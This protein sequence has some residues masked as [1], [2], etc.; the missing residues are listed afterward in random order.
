MA[1]FLG[2]GLAAAFFLATFLPAGRGAVLVFIVGAVRL[3][4]GLTFAGWLARLR[5][6][7]GAPSAS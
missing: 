4:R 5:V 3:T 2:S 1:P 7:V 6:R